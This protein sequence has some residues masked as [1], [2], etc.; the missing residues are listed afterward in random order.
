METNNPETNIE[1]SIIY[2]LSSLPD[3][4]PLKIP[5]SLIP[6]SKLNKMTKI[7]KL[8]LFCEK[9]KDEN[10][11]ND[12]ETNELKRYLRECLNRKK[13]QNTKE[14]IYDKDS[15]MITSIP[16]LTISDI[17]KSKD[18]IRKF[19]LKS[20]SKQSMRL[21]SQIILRS[22]TMKNTLKKNNE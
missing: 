3:Q 19:T 10:T 8:N 20:T 4:T 22:K 21:S 13:L 14:V 5:S 17:P 12:E 6:W 9:Y 16:N 11:L 18:K 2:D 15:G 1:S 7:N